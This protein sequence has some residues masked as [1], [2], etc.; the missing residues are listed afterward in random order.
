MKESIVVNV[1][2]GINWNNKTENLYKNENINIIV[3]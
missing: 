1:K 2:Q 3:F